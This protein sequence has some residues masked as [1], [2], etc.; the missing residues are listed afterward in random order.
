[1]ASDIMYDNLMNKFEYGNMNDPDVYI[2]ENN[3]RMMTNI[4]NS[5]NRL[6]Y[7]LISE[8]KKDSAIAVIDRC[9]ELIPNEIVQY[10]YFALELAESYFNAGASEKGKEIVEKAFDIYNNELSYFLSLDNKF[11]QTPSINEEMQRNFYYMQKMER[12]VRLDGDVEMS[13]KIAET[14]QMHFDNYN[15]I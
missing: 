4:R 11:V 1:V 13:K 3:A 15:S 7:T 2:D 10:E 5:F 9:F 14:I 6:A 12:M 8:G